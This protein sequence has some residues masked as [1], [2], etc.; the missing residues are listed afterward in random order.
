MAV[1]SKADD[2]ETNP[3]FFSKTVTGDLTKAVVNTS[4]DHAKCIATGSDPV[5]F[6]SQAPQFCLVVSG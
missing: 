5:E 1:G 3:H 2:L 4:A 6:T